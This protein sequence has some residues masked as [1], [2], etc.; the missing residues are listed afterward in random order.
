MVT[1]LSSFRVVPS[2]CKIFFEIFIFFWQP[3]NIS[4]NVTYKSCS[5]AGSWIFSFLFG[6]PDVNECDLN[7]PKPWPNPPFPKWKLKMSSSKWLVNGFRSKMLSLCLKNES[8]GLLDPKNCL[9]VSLGS[10]LKS[11]DVKVDVGRSAKRLN[12]LKSSA[13]SD[14]DWWTA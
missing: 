6:V 9:N 3:V 10:I 4:S 1:S 8:K 5:I 12:Y 14:T 7:P 11:N 13:I 2:G